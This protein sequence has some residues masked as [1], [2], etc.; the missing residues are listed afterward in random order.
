VTS[1]APPGGPCP[2]GGTCHHECS[3]VAW[4]FRVRCCSPL[5]A[6]GWG[7]E[8]P[9]VIRAMAAELDAAAKHADTDHDTIIA[10]WRLAIR[11]RARARTLRTERSNGT[12]SEVVADTLE[13]V[14][15]E[16]KTALGVPGQVTP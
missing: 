15:A 11:L 8:W 14:G 13:S 5:T 12:V 2:D 9:P 10:V 16:I 3:S 6:A 7:D 1:P 4:C